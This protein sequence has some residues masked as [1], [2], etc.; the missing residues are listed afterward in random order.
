MTRKASFSAP[1]MAAWFAIISSSRVLSS[2]SAARVADD[3]ASA[4]GRPASSAADWTPACS[5]RMT[6]GSKSARRLRTPGADLIAPARA[7]CPPAR[8]WERPPVPKTAIG[9]RNGMPTPKA[10][11]RGVPALMSMPRR[12]ASSSSDWGAILAPWLVMWAISSDVLPAALNSGSRCWNPSVKARLV[13][14][15]VWPK[16]PASLP[17]FDAAPKGL[18][19]VPGSRRISAPMGRTF[20]SNQLPLLVSYPAFLSRS[21]PL[22][23]FFGSVSPSVSE[24]GTMD[25]ASAGLPPRMPRTARPPNVLSS[26]EPTQCRPDTA[27][28]SRPSLSG[29]A[30]SGA[31]GGYFAVAR[32]DWP[33]PP[34]TVSLRLNGFKSRNGSSL[35]PKMSRV[36][37]PIALSFFPD[38]RHGAAA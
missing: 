31:R 20:L 32:R 11:R 29:S 23:T 8:A 17:A 19:Y 9:S 1:G 36:V 30:T 37:S 34:N 2:C 12:P 35:A 21:E 15:W 38:V 22:T 28:S 6:S 3:A 26:V 24:K 7:S 4:A 13:Q 16:P 25:R 33:P 27:L 5:A 10:P 14:P 18:M